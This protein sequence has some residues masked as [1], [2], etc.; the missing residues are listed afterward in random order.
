MVRSVLPELRRTM[1][2][3]MPQIVPATVGIHVRRGDYVGN[4]LLLSP[5]YYRG[6][7]NELF[8]KHELDPVKTRVVVFSDDPEWCESSLSFDVPVDFSPPRDTK[9]DFAA[10]LASE[11]LVL[12]R[13]TFSWWAGVLP[14]R[15]ERNV[16]SPFPYT[17][18]PEAVLDYSGWL[19]HPVS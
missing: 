12:S 9:E 15:P 5:E 16:I 8:A 7:L 10:L 17:P 2:A 14:A 19:R 11:Y 4:D 18:Y 3:I 1:A 6:A 13:S